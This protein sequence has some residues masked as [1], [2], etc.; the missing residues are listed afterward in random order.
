[1]ANNNIKMRL[2]GNIYHPELGNNVY[3]RRI[4]ANSS[5]MEQVVEESSVAVMSDPRVDEI[6]TMNATI[7]DNDCIITYTLATANGME[8]DGS[9]N[10]GSITTGGGNE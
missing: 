5:G 6:I 10:I 8:V 1:M 4:K 9:V 2:G 7:I 3:G